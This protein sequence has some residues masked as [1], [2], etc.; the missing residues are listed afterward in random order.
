MKV[1][2][3]T[4]VLID[5]AVRTDEYPHSIKVVN[6][7]MVHSGVSPWVSGISLNNIEYIVSKLGQRQKAYQLLQFI[8]DRFSI[9]PFRKSAFVRALNIGGPDFEDAIQMASA[10]QLGMDYIVTRNTD[11]FRESEV[12]A[13]TPSEFL[14]KWNAGDFDLVSGVPF[15]DLKAQHHQIYNEI[16]DRIT[17]VITN[18][19]FILG[20]H[21]EEFE[22]NFAAAIGVKHCIGVGNGTDALFIAMKAL[23][24]GK[25]DDVITA[26]NSFIATSE[27]ITMTGAKV[28]FVDIDPQTYN[29]SPEKIEEK[30]S[31]MSRE[32]KAR[33][34]AI[35][36]VHLY[37]QP[38]DMDPILDIAKKYNLFIIEDAAQAHLAEYKGKTVGTFGDIACFSFY[39]GKNLG[40]YGDAGAIVTDNKELATRARMIANHGRISKYDHEFEGVNSRMDGIQGATLN[41]KLRHLPEWTEMRRKAASIYN[42]LLNEQTDIITPKV[43]QYAKHVYHLYVIRTKEREKLQEYL[44][45]KGIS[46]GVHYPISLPNLMA[47]R[48]LGHSPSDFSVSSQYQDEILSLPMYPE[49]KEEQVEYVV[50]CIADL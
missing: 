13:V 25:G 3:D 15:L 18:T 32:Q 50:S 40:A 20:K 41:V 19:A 34:K 27:A 48:Y 17:D 37:G 36:P 11:H 23:G 39:P 14:E 1:F 30:I 8:R 42:R 2:F 4:N 22:E 9:I 31:A 44:K 38:A 49:L 24:I 28:A 10:E 46:T 33:L 12:P 43:A 5:V 29:I 21:V 26:A 16:D 7:V 45:T 35:I 47:Y 6:E